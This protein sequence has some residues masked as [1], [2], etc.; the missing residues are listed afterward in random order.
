MYE[1]FNVSFFLV[2]S[3]S[4]ICLFFNQT[5]NQEAASS[6]GGT[7][8]AHICRTVE[9]LIKKQKGKEMKEKIKN[10]KIKKYS[11]V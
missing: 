4:Y 2:L 10:C 11:T 3:L 9:I 6:N 8:Q 5:V 1:N 7:Q